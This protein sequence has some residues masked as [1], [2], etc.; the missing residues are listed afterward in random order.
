MLPYFLGA[1]FMF[2]VNNT[3]LCMVVDTLAVVAGTS[4]ITGSILIP[5]DQDRDSIVIT[6]T[7]LHPISGENVRHDILADQLGKFSLD[8]DIETETSFIGLYTSVNPQEVYYIKSIN[9]DSVRIDI[10]YDSGSQVKN[11]DVTHDISPS[12]MM[13]SMV[14]LNQMIGYRPT[15]PDW[16]YPHLYNKSIHEFLDDVKRNESQRL[17]LFVEDNEL[18]SDAFKRLVAKNYRLFLYTAH[19]LN[20]ESQMLHNYR[21]A[22]GDLTGKPVFKKIDRSYFQFLKNLELNDSQY[23][24]TFTFPEFQDSILRNDVLRLP[25][26]GESDIPS[27]LVRVKGILSDLVGFEEGPY[28]DILA[29]NAYSRQLNEQVM[30]LSERQK[31][32]IVDYWKDGEIAKILF[33]KNEEIVAFNRLKSPLVVQDISPVQEEKVMETIVSKY[34]DKVVF[35]DFWATWCVPCLEAM[36]QFRKI[37]GEFG[38]EDVAFVYI[39]NGSSPQ[40]LWEEKIVGI[41][42]EHYYLT[43]K[44]WNYMMKHFGFDGIPSY[45]VLDKKGLL[46]KKFTGF[47]GNNVVKALID[48]LLE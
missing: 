21:N 41:G 14:A 45:L 11:I 38:D 30:P 33:R 29:A 27:W 48:D 8:F 19:V 2:W 37:K 18:L 32:H 25:V 35:V 6:I 44:Q 26:I 34:K 39:T 7:V 12:D 42:G 23:L 10:V 47:P 9:N 31:E 1:F 4:K 46:V 15:D 36:K 13:H 43:D 28:Y 40:K 17:G 3:A 20:Y 24:Q 5:S 22:T 16:K